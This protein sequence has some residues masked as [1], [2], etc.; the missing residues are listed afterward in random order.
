MLRSKD[1]MST[2]FEAIFHQ[3]RLDDICLNCIRCT[4]AGSAILLKTEVRRSKVK[5][6]TR[7]QM[8][9]KVKA[10][11]LMVPCRIL[12]ILQVAHAS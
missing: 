3:R 5:V 1:K 12:S 2:S 4:V 7:P 6:T 10:Y 9:K 8:V 11:A